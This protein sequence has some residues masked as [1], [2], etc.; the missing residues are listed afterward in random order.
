VNDHRIVKRVSKAGFE[1]RGDAFLF[2]NGVQISSPRLTVTM[3]KP[4]AAG[5]A[6]LELS[7]WRMYQFWYD[8]ILKKYG[9]ERAQLLYTDTDSLVMAIQTST[10]D[11]DKLEFAHEMDFSN[12]KG[13]GEKHPLYREGVAK[14][15][16]YFKEETPSED[17]EEPI[18]AFAGL[19]NK[20]YAVL[21][22]FTWTAKN[23]GTSTKVIEKSLNEVNKVRQTMFELYKNTLLNNEMVNV[24]N[25]INIAE[26]RIASTN[27]DGVQRTTHRTVGCRRALNCYDDKRC[28][29]D[30][31]HEVTL[32]DTSVKTFSYAHGHCEL[33]K[34]LYEG[35]YDNYGRVVC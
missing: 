27:C 16:W 11:K 10:W 6:V 9:H 4:I 18:V 29:F 2:S 15:P 21:G 32:C 1:F 31:H 17:P 25:V 30:P 26:T 22:L 23:K 12:Y 28:H 20:S 13:Y 33:R 14:Y 19:T 7:K 24:S 35:L 3:N 5:A 8:V 34:K